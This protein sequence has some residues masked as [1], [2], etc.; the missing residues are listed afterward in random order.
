MVMAMYRGRHRNVD[1]YAAAFA[2]AIEWTLQSESLPSAALDHDPTRYLPRLQLTAP[3]GED[4]AA[5]QAG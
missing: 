2:D 1:E 5:A 4:D 3:A